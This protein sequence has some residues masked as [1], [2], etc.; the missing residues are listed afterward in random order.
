[1]ESEEESWGRE[2]GQRKG[3]EKKGGRKEENGKEQFS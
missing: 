3:T 2:R 1:L